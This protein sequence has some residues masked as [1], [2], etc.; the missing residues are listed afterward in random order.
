MRIFLSLMAILAA[1]V[2]AFFL[3]AGCEPM[4]PEV[5]WHLKVHLVDKSTN[6]I[7]GALVHVHAHG[8]I[9][10]INTVFGDRHKEWDFQTNTDSDGRC[11]ADVRACVLYVTA[12]KDGFVEPE[13]QA[14]HG[15]GNAADADRDIQI[16]MESKG[17]AQ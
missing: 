15:T 5:D 3:F 7:A 2:I 8:K 17:A 6:G 4:V 14:L 12:T 11:G 1:L 16:V 9:T 13:E 10:A